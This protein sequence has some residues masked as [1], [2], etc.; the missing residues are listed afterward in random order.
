M[1]HVL[2]GDRY[3]LVHEEEQGEQGEQGEQEMQ[4]M[5]EEQEE[6]EMQEMQEMQEVQDNIKVKVKRPP[7]TNCCARMSAKSPLTRK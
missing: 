1:V 4:E 5:Q 6:Q 3:K 7:T 2:I